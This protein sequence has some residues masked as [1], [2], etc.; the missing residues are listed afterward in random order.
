M[1]IRD[2][3]AV[4]PKLSIGKRTAG[5]VGRLS[6][7][8][9]VVRYLVKRFYSYLAIKANVYEDEKVE[10]AIVWNYID[11][12]HNGKS[13]KLINIGYSLYFTALFAFTR[14]P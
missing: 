3:C 4:N 11:K 13:H 9:G 6:K 7:S 14:T 5:S 2:F 12:R 8:R 1:Q 10:I